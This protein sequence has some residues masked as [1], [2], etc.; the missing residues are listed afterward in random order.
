M[1]PATGLGLLI[2]LPASGLRLAAAAPGDVSR[3]VLP[4]ADAGARAALRGAAAASRGATRL[5]RATQ[6]A[7]TPG[8]C[9]VGARRLHVPLRPRRGAVLDRR[10]L[11]SA[12]RRVAASL[13][14]HPEVLAAYWDGG[15][16]SLVVQLAEDAVTDKVAARAAR[17]AA[18][19]QL[20]QPEEPALD[21]DHPGQ[22]ASARVHATALC[23]D[24]AG[25]ATATTARVLRL[26][27]S[28][29]MV[30]AAVTAL[31]EDSRPRT[32]LRHRLGEP[33][34]DLVLSAAYAAAHGFGQSPTALVLDASLRA[35][36]LLE[37]V[38]R[39]ALFDEAHDRL[40]DPDRHSLPTP[41]A[42]RPRLHVMPAQ[43]Y[44]D[45]AVTGGLLGA[46]ATLAFTRDGAEAAEAVLAA[47]PRAARYGPVAFTAAL[48]TGLARRRVLVRD[49]ERIR[50][51]ELV[52]TVVLHH[53]VL[54]GHRRTLLEASPLGED[55]DHDRLWH[56][57]TATLRAQ[58]EKQQ[59]GK[60][61]DEVK[62]RLRAPAG[63][64]PGTR[65]GRMTALDDDNREVGNVFVAREV[66]PLAEAV[67]D[68]ARRAGLHVVVADDGT[69]GEFGALADQL[70]SAEAT[71]TETVRQLRQSRRAV[72]TVAR[73]A[74][75]AGADDDVPTGLLS[76]D[77]AVTVVDPGSAVLWAADALVLDDLSG[78]W[79]LLTA[80]PGSRAAAR[81][82]KVLA[83]AGAALSELMV[84]TRGS[85]GRRAAWRVGL[86]LSPVNAAA[87]AALVDGWR[88][89]R[90]VLRPDVP[91]PRPRVPWHALEPHEVLDRLREAERDLHEESTRATSA[92]GRLGRSVAASP[93][94]VPLRLTG[95]LVS[96]VRA[97]LDDP[98]TP[99]LAVGATASALLGSAVDAFL[100]T[101][102][103][104]IN[105]LVGGIQR[106]R[107]EQALASL[108]VTQRQQAR[109]VVDPE[110]GD[111]RT[112]E[113]GRLTPGEI[114]ELQTGDVVPADARLIE[115]E[116]LEVDES[117]LT[118]ESLPTLKQTEP[119]PRVPVPDRHCMVFQG[120]TV[121]AGQGRAVVVDTGDDTEAGRAAHLAARMPPAPGVQA[122]LREL[123][124]TVLPLTL[125]G[126]A[127]VT[128]LSLLRGTPVRQAVAGGLAVAVAAVPE[129]LPLTATVAQLA[130]ARRLTAH[131]VLVRTPRTLEALGRMDTVCF[132]KT[133]TLTEN[134]LRVVRTAASDGG[135]HE[136]DSPE[137][138]EILRQAARTCP[139]VGEDHGVH[140]HA[141]DGAV[142][143]AAGDDPHWSP[144]DTQPFQASRGYASAT[145]HDAENAALLV[146]K[147]APEVVLPLCPDADDSATET[148]QALA[149]EGLRVLAVAEYHLQSGEFEAALERP[150]EHYQLHL[151]GFIALAD[152]PRSDAAPLIS[153][154]R[155]AGVRPVM[156]T[157]DHPETARAVAV[158]LGWPKDVSVVTGDELATRDRTGRA[159]LVRDCGVVA[160]V[161]P[162][163]KLQV[164]EALRESGRVVGMVGDGSNDAAAIRAADVGVGI[165]VRGSAAARNAADL[166]IVND[167]LSALIEA[168]AEGRALWHSVADALTVL[169]GGNAG[170]IG[171]SLLGT[172]ISGASPLSTRQLLLVNL[173]TDMFPAMAVAVT[174][175]GATGTAA[176]ADETGTEG[177][178]ARTG[179]APLGLGTLGAPL[180]RQIRHRGILT[181]LGAAAAWLVGTV[182]PGSARRT[183]TMALCGVVGA[184]LTQTVTGRRHSP[185]VWLTVLGSAAA[186][187][188]VIQTPGVSQFFGCTPLGPIAWAGVA[189]AVALAALAPRSPS[190]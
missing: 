142:V 4:L 187:I 16:E 47:A 56:A 106:L 81:H 9:W 21:H 121:V 41:Q 3:H 53:S 101:G 79:R 118:G 64:A 55:W 183:S 158:A 84:L 152:T 61:R 17:L 129:G 141:T 160:R 164:I 140:A 11:E 30:T 80:V 114:I 122:R 91:R 77:V 119:T 82:A 162:E 171:F 25:I 88:G 32:W 137:G 134:R 105:A 20:E 52:D 170:E 154:L 68:A 149:A 38:T 96:A 18:D 104:G 132:D 14:E 43:Q 66:D 63:S 127:A 169:I 12:A 94:A 109:R 161:A 60:R 99:V 186:L 42:R 126:G 108:A 190:R 86:R 90:R 36:Q 153:G 28:P 8:R 15:L 116:D 31:R 62:V 7:M 22:A 57:A 58:D 181:A 76:S 144:G 139:P 54:S 131:G 172:A 111:T 29:R 85:R 145:G 135:A 40:C 6:Q 10:Q 97:E 123:T 110:T 39:A 177:Q 133:G 5:G 49:L 143:D 74:A 34:A 112:V 65:T 98:L 2:G 148:A 151:S 150:L 176:G 75:G 138:R 24:M 73:V 70:V 23:C 37:S 87:A 50:Q 167:E 89:A 185:L 13:T 182:T 125:A 113:A 69:L 155:E 174:P 117:S 46:V 136:N 33:T 26:R 59:D 179:T 173:L 180:A 146:V 78:V 188:A 128:G 1:R 147:G 35:G 120:A 157:G 107:A 184:Q 168:V 93:A 159:S 178:G 67:L 48:G 27:P 156:L 102:A 71:L 44:A 72:L 130:A 115:A 19:Q 103:M 92:A 124:S 163:Q 95:R 45:Q 175:Q 166:V 189:A 83:E 51:L 100:V 165:A